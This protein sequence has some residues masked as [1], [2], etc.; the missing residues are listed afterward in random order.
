MERLDE[1]C[2]GMRSQTAS[3]DM[4][5]APT[6]FPAMADLVGTLSDALQALLDVLQEA[7]VPLSPNPSQ[8]HDQHSSEFMSL[9]WNIP[10]GMPLYTKLLLYVLRHCV[11][12]PHRLEMELDFAVDVYLPSPVASS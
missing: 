8:E 11:Q 7:L 6:V 2:S 12:T 4:Q 5:C 3:I 1:V 10:P 9:S